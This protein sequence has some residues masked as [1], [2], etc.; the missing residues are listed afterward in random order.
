MNEYWKL[1][2]KYKKNFD[3]AVKK[4]QENCDHDWGTWFLPW[5]DNNKF[6]M[7]VC[8]VCRTREKRPIDFEA[9]KE[10]ESLHKEGNVK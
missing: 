6:E 7:R 9:A 8:K 5:V 2:K 3:R 10:S 4:L 1:E